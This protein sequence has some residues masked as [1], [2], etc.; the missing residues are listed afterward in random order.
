MTKPPESVRT[1]WDGPDHGRHIPFGS[2]SV[3]HGAAVF[4]G[5]RCYATASGP[6]LFRADDHLVRLLNSA[7]LLGLGHDYELARLR[8]AVVD[9]AAAT[10]LPGCYVR[11]GLFCPDPLLTIDLGRLRFRLGI[12]MWPMSPTPV[13]PRPVRLTV[14]PWRRPSPLSFPPRAKAV[15]TYVTSAVAKTAAVAAG[16]DDAVQ[17]DPD[18]GRVAEATTTNIFLVRAGVLVTPWL[19][20]NLLAGI[21]RDSVLVLA[22]ELGIPVRE[23]PVDLA[24][25][26]AA[27]EVF[28]TGTAGELAPVSVLDEHAYPA[29]RPVFDAI[30]A[31]FHATVTGARPDHADWLTPVPAAPAS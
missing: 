16:F 30:A 10:G 28:L 13:P 14:S 20:D 12:E 23:G 18:S 7:R 6:A 25:L 19:T 5:I 29:A 22:R 31:A 17:L 27:D 3:Q 1:F 21:T 24:E 8:A 26:R 15:G 4:E 9:A 11:P 2:T